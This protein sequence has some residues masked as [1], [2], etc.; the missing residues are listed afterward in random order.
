MKIAIYH[1]FSEIHYEMLG[2]LLEYMIHKNI[3]M[4]IYAISSNIVGSSWK[5][6]YEELFKRTYIWYSPNL[7]NP[8]L[9]D[10]I[11]LLTDDDKS[12]KD[13]WLY[14]IGN[15]KVISIEH[16]GLI[17]RSNIV[18]RLCTRQFGLR[19]NCK[20]ALPCYYGITK[21]EKQLNLRR[22]NKIKIVCIGIQNRPS[23]IFLQKLL[24]DFE[25]CEIHVIARFF[26]ECINLPNIFYYKNYPVDLMFELVKKSHYILC[27]NNPNNPF[28]IANSISGAI[29]LGLSYGCQLI[30]PDLW[31]TYYNFKSCISYKDEDNIKVSNMIPLDEIYDELNILIEH[32]N[33]TIHSFF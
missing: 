17:R 9:Y 30:I 25:E 28:P 15:E 12:F 7:F 22:E 21:E 6:Y 24:I 2:Y 5:K 10:K 19:P 32:K 31:Q 8:Y 11:I 27:I 16:C 13:E 14:E 4:N 20:W 3:D 26:D 29:P 33:N 18:H 1:G 23:L